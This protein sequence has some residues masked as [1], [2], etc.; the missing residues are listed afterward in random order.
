MDNCLSS[1]YRLGIFK[2]FLTAYLFIVLHLSNMFRENTVACYL[3][4]GFC[5]TIKLLSFDSKRFEFIVGWNVI[6]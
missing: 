1:D 5:N 6:R 2:R 4:L 3:Y